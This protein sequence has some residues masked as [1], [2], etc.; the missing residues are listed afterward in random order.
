MEIYGIRKTLAMPPPSVGNS[1]PA[2]FQ[3]LA[4]ATSKHPDR[5]AF[6]GG[7]ATL[8]IMFHDAVRSGE[9]TPEARTRFE[10]MAL[11]IVRYG[12]VGFGELAAEHFS[13]REGHPYETAPPDHPLLLLLADIAARNEMTIDLHM[14]AIARDM[15]FDSTFQRAL[16][17]PH[18]PS[19][20][21][22]NI[23]G[24]ERLLDHNKEARIVWL[25][26]GWDNTGF[27]TFDLMERLLRDHPNL[28]M[29]IKLGSGVS[30]VSPTRPVDELG[31][32]K[33]EW[34]ALM[35]LFPDRFMMGLDGGYTSADTD[36]LRPPR[37]QVITDILSQLPPD[38][39]HLVAYENAVSIYRLN[40]P[41]KPLPTPEPLALTP[42]PTVTPTPLP[43]VEPVE[44]FAPVSVRVTFSEGVDGRAWAFEGS[45]GYGESDGAVN[46][47]QALNDEIG[48]LFSREPISSRRFNVSFSFSIGEGSGADGLAFVVSRS[49]P[50]GSD[51]RQAVRGGDFGFGVLDGFAIEFDT[52]PGEAEDPNLEHVGLD[53]TPSGEALAAQE[54]SFSL[55]NN[56]FFDA[57]IVF[58]SGHAQVYLENL[59][60]GL[61]QTRVLDYTIPGFVPFDGYFGFVASTGSRNDRHA[62]YGVVFEGLTTPTPIPTPTPTPTLI[63]TTSASLSIQ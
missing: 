53:I 48:Y 11:E 59:S 45:A 10:E 30:G 27:R 25:H 3:A 26:A 17:S 23:E 41:P 62:I 19:V 16:D 51:V 61:A 31:V 54:L 33:P 49:I 15:P 18:K 44:G 4:H 13:F 56:G 6:L 2:V 34:V 52:W 9:V 57:T 20:L 35:R 46:L 32:L 47:T 21:H 37:F 5:L 14:E 29:N 42:P 38:L 22:E 8:N 28:Y 7:G 12:A 60:I 55:R 43:T 40:R 1:T 36:D 50:T 63:P 58:D 24:F 39:V